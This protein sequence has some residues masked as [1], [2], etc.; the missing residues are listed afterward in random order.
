MG[1]LFKV[2]VDAIAIAAIPTLL[3]VFLGW[4]IVK[5]VKV[6]EVFVEG[7]KDGFQVA[8]RIIPYLVA[9]LVAI[10][11]FRASGAMDLLTAL[12]APIASLIGMPPEALP[13]ALMRPLS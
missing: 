12:L 7:A 9:M 3:A 4:G 2:T 1:E 11:I 6:Y 13:M 5:K 10:G 8:V